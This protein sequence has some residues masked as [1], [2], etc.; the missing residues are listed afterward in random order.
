M[1]PHNFHAA[2]WQKDITPLLLSVF[3]G[4]FAWKTFPFY[5][6]KT[7]GNILKL[8]FKSCFFGVH[9]LLVFHC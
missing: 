8:H 9:R 7:L 1:A 4:E 5:T 6:L 3:A 2:N